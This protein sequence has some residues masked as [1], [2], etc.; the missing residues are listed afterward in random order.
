MQTVPYWLDYPYEPRAALDAEVE[1]DAC[2]IGAGV[3]G[4]ACARELAR[5]GLDPVLLEARTVASGSLANDSPDAYAASCSITVIADLLGEILDHEDP[6]RARRIAL[7]PSELAVAE[8]FI[9]PR[10]LKADRYGRGASKL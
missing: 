1:A 2:V 8:L 9:E 10:R 7:D 5:R 4:L 3:S 6:A